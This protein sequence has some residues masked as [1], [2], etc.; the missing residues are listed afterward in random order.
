MIGLYYEA[1]CYRGDFTPPFVKQIPAK[2]SNWWNYDKHILWQI[3]NISYL[4]A[5]EILTFGHPNTL[6]NP[7]NRTPKSA[8]KLNNSVYF[9][10][11]KLEQRMVLCN[12]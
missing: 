11:K 12:T 2:V 4:K 5:Y 6:R 9:T 10:D 3:F 7:K 1:Q 8:L